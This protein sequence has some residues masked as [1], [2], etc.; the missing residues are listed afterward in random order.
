MRPGSGFDRNLAAT[1][2]WLV[3]PRIVGLRAGARIPYIQG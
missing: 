3:H 2:L 1:V